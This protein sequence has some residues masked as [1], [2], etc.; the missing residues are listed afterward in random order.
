MEEKEEVNV[1]VK[2]KVKV[3]DSTSTYRVVGF[4]VP[5]GALIRVENGFRVAEGDVLFEWEPYS[6]PLLARAK[7][8]VRFKDIEVGRTMREDIDERT[9][10]MQRIIVEDRARKLHP[11]LEVIDEKGRVC[12]THS[13]PAGAYLVVEDKQ[14]VTEGDVL[15]RLL[16]EMART[17]D[18]TGGLPKVAELFE[19]KRVKSPAIISEIDGTVDVGEP[20]EGKRLVRVT[21]EGGATK[22]YEIP[23]G[24]FLLVQTGDRV[25]A[26]DKLCEGSVDPHDVLKVKGWL[27]VQEFLTNQ[28][29]AVYRLQ[30]VKIN[31]KHISVIVRQMLRKV[32]I[33]DA[34]DSN[35]IEGEIVERRR[36]IE[37][38]GR[39]ISEGLRPATYQPILLG[40]TRAALLTESFL[41]AAS[42]Q[43]T[44]RVLSE[45][46]IQGR[47]DRLRGLKENVIVGRL[48]PAGTGFRQFNRIKLITEEAKK[49][50]QEAA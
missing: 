14:T 28:I 1:K 12:D 42:F 18:I 24:K 48:I 39:L 27:A 38:N 19:A 30:K 8:T 44:T 13:L 7:G 34:G 3:K 17:R 40:I 10:R 43:E 37:E 47:E 21:S 31:D 22:E 2:V 33:E 9:E 50:E 25:R 23:Y 41:S 11:M 16:R 4:T 46:A 29:Q 26:G 35:F 49:E 15:A 36:V 6:I 5:A 20:R 45:A 32:R